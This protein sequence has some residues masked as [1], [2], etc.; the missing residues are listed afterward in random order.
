MDA[1]GFA[2]AVG[3]T[4]EQQ[5]RLLRY[6]DVLQRWQRRIN[7]VGPSTLGD[8]WRRHF[9]DSAQLLPLLPPRTR[10]LVDLGSGAGFPGMV[11]AIF[12]VPEV[13]LIEADQRKA[14]FLAEVSR[15]T[16]T[17]VTIH[18]QRI[19]Q[20]PSFP[21]DAITARALAPLA[22]LLRLAAPFAVPHTVAVFP[23][24]RDVDKELTTLGELPKMTIERLPSRT[25]PAGTLLRIQGL[26]RD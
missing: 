10:V 14:I 22:T 23:K 8:V 5:D 20:V 11:L 7:L 15:E 2:Q 3:A 12:G 17:P 18:P 4:A 24:G 6:A 9:L 25:D 21:A 19:D 13:H 26:G 16:L 1:I